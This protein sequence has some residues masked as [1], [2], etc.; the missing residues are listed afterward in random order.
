MKFS[1]GAFFAYAIL[2]FS[3]LLGLSSGTAQAAEPDIFRTWMTPKG[4]TV[5]LAACEGKICG[6]IQRLHPA[7]KGPQFVSA[8]HPDPTLRGQPL[9]GFQVLE[10]FQYAGDGRWKRGKVHDTRTFKT[11]SSKLKLQDDGSLKISAC[12]MVFCESRLWRPAPSKVAFNVS[13][14]E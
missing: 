6:Y 3:P 11:Y 2:V 4:G 7:Y 13:S 14:G 9:V 8:D 5:I 12:V 10:N 1:F